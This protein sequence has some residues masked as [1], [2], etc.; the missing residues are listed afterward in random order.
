LGQPASVAA[1]DDHIVVSD[2]LNVR[3]LRLT[4]TFASTKTIKLQ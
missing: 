1:D 2:I 4:K 3:L